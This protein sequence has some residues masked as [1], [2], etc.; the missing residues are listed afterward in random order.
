MAEHNRNIQCT[1]D[2]TKSPKSEPT[3]SRRVSFELNGK[4]VHDEK[5]PAISPETDRE[6]TLELDERTDDKVPYVD[7]NSV[8][9]EPG[10]FNEGFLCDDK[11]I[12][13]QFVNSEKTTYELT[14]HT[15]T[16]IS[17]SNAT[18]LRDV[19]LEESSNPCIKSKVESDGSSYGKE[20]QSDHMSEKENI[21][22]LGVNRHSDANSVNDNIEQNPNKPVVKKKR[23]VRKRMSEIIDMSS[24][25]D[26]THDMYSQIKCR[27][28]KKRAYYS[29]KY[30]GTL[31]YHTESSQ[32]TCSTDSV[33]SVQYS[34]HMANTETDSIKN[35]TQA[36]N[37]S[38][39]KVMF[40]TIKDI[41]R[42]SSE[43]SDSFSLPDDEYQTLKLNFVRNNLVTSNSSK[44][45]STNGTNK[46]TL[47]CDTGSKIVQQKDKNFTLSPKLIETTAVPVENKVQSTEFIHGDG[48]NSL[49]ANND[50]QNYYYRLKGVIQ[51]WCC[52]HSCIHLSIHP[53]IQSTIHTKARTVC[54]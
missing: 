9:N 40:S 54:H 13:T 37:P 52:I 34:Q 41:S 32:S 7:S 46:V 45:E 14:H 23:K 6:T 16:T 19:G 39:I 47:Q 49:M 29:Q 24:L 1:P 3:H 31:E 51:V 53:S 48:C 28:S 17:T 2:I 22:S 38:Q 4:I 42:L 30:I 21:K 8:L 15:K 20:N 10:T 18:N 5:L 12:D 36:I 11:S 25:E 27:R 33:I 26:D 43:M 44:S 50:R 35:E